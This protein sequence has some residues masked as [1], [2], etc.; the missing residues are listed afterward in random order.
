[1]QASSTWRLAG[2]FDCDRIKKETT[3]PTL[4]QI[5]TSTAIP[6]GFHGN[7]F[8]YWIGTTAEKRTGPNYLGILTVGWCYILS[9]RLVEMRGDGASMRYTSSQANSFS[10]SLRGL[11][12][13]HVIDVGDVEGDVARWWSA[14]LAQH[15]GWKAIVKQTTSGEYLAPWSVTRTCETT[16]AISQRRRSPKSAQTPLPSD[17]ALNALV[18]FARLHELGSQFPVALA[19]AISFPA[20]QY[21]GSIARLPL[22]KGDGGKIP[23]SPLD[24]ISLM[25]TDWKDELPY[26]MTLSCSPEV[27]MSTL[28]GS[29][30][31]AGVPCNLVSPWLH[32]VLEE[33]LGDASVINDHDQELLGL[34]GAIRRPTVSALWIGAVISGLGPKIVRKVMSGRP[35][36]DS[37]AFPWT[38]CPQ[39]F[40]DIPGS[41]PY[42]CEDLEYISRP[43]VWR[44]L[45]LPS[46]EHDDLCYEFRPT[47][48]WAPCGRS[49]TRNCAL[50]VTSHLKC[51]R[52]EYRYDHWSWSLGDGTIVQ[53]HGFSSASASVR[54]EAPHFADARSLVHFEKKELDRTASREASLD[55]FRWF[56]VNGEG[57]P[58]EK[59]YQDD[60]VREIW[61]EDE[62]DVEADEIDERG[63]QEPVDRNDDRL[64]TWL[65]SGC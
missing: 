26:Y 61:G 65:D 63:P 23:T 32:P 14:I 9:A 12:G 54:A 17:R 60:W 24:S 33:V 64:E 44:L 50:R 53:D 19:T 6:Y 31:E 22:P 39:S 1:M 38:S 8:S 48:P 3:I 10:E 5:G 16:F 37:L 28:C 20:H 35:P 11:P 7:I 41:G 49:L 13:I 55:I 15:Q 46:A 51:P 47:T 62:S 56:F 57:L 21:Y 45:H 30:W 42:S 36:L 58:L 59:V 18:Q 4:L 25:R 27:M 40:M 34:L 2:D 52:H 29:F 43:D